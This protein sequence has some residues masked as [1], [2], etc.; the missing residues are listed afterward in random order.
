MSLFFAFLIFTSTTLNAVA[1]TSPQ[2][3]VSEDGFIEMPAYQTLEDVS[4]QVEGIEYTLR[5]GTV[6]TM[7]TAQNYHAKYLN[8]G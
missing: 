1:Y 2:G 3:A 4:I 8:P 7:E 5:A 6:I